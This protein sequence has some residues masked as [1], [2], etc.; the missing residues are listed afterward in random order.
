MSAL[1]SYATRYGSFTLILLV[2]AAFAAAENVEPGWAWGWPLVILVPLSL[3][4][5]WDLVQTRHSLMRNFPVIAHFRWMF[6]ELRP[7]LRQYIVEDDLSGRPYS[8]HQRSLVYQRAKDT[9]DAQ[10]LGTSL[11]VYGEEY[12]L[13]AHS[14]APRA[15]GD[16]DFRVDI[17]GPQCARPYIASI[18]NISAMSFGAL[19]SHAIQA[20]NMGAKLDNF[21]H[22][23]GEGGLS[24][25]HRMHGGD[26]VWEIGSG[27]FGCRN[28]HG[29]FDDGLFAEQ[30]QSEQV[31]MVEIKLSQGAKPGHGGVLPGSKVTPEIAEARNVEVGQDCISPAFHTAF[32][33]PVQLLEFAAKL[34]DLSGGKPVGVKLC[35]G[36]PWETF[37]VCKAMLE[38]GIR[39]DFVVVDGA[40]GGTGAAPEEFSD[41]MGMPL[42]E[43]LV[44]VRNALVGSN[45]RGDVRLA[46]SGKVYSAFSIAANLALG[47]DW[48]NA[49]RA[50]MFSLGCVMSKRCHT[51]K[52]PTGVATQD[53]GRQ[54]GLV[55]SE[56]A[57]RV[58]NFHRNTLKRLAELVAATGLEH[59]GELTPHHLFH[60]DTPNSITTFDGIT[61]FL[62]PGVLVENPASTSYAAWWAAA[63]VDSFAPTQS[64]G[65]VHHRVISVG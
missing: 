49:A 35:V 32:G 55:I 45:L 64:T 19:G 40:E 14:I 46:A 18:L 48:C 57:R 3:L 43:G 5:M 54:R 65:P 6:E 28:G 62:E 2:T 4:G 12:E 30:A 22:D 9:V 7:F 13:L 42:R 63:S 8:R 51:D 23:T 10:P 41:H 33:T 25:Y 60:R 26:L 20:L 61:E 38:T 44:F 34:R 37:A 21:Y 56:K 15:L 1:F 47:A 53:P 31:K 58:A 59:P 11:D 50:F 24:R 36:Q 29:K 27:Y 52:C 17:G 39:L 16:S